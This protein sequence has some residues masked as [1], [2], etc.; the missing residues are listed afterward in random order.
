MVSL[1]VDSLFTHIP[2]DETIEICIKELFTDKDISNRLDKCQL[3]YLLTI[4]TIVFF[5]LDG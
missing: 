5:H 3:K 1:D 2:L 4:A